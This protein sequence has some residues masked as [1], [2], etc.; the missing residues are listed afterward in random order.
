MIRESSGMREP[1]VY[2]ST[3]T[4]AISWSASAPVSGRSPTRRPPTAHAS[5]LL[6][7]GITMRIGRTSKWDPQKEEFPDA[8][9]ANRLLSLAAR[10][11]GAIDCPQHP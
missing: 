2:Y 1:G 5:L 4:R 8:P 7:G 3:A 10:E 9:D 6:L 11:P